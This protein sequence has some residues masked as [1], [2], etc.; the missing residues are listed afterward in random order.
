MIRN[1]DIN[2]LTA[3][4][5]LF[6]RPANERQ[7]YNVTPSLF[8]WVRAENDTCNSFFPTRVKQW[9]EMARTYIK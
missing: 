5:M 3:G 4:I 8:G 9:C 6:M 2:W 1:E 7:R